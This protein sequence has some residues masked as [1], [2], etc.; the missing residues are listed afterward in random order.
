MCLGKPR[1]YSEKTLPPERDAKVDFYFDYTY[2]AGCHAIFIA[3]L[4]ASSYCSR[5]RLQYRILFNSTS[6]N[7][8]S[9]WIHPEAIPVAFGLQKEG[10]DDQNCVLYSRNFA[11]AFTQLLADQPSYLNLLGQLKEAAEK[12]ACV[13]ADYQA[14]KGKDDPKSVLRKQEGK[15]FSETVVQMLKPYL[16]QYY[17]KSA[18]GE[19][20]EKSQESIKRYHLNLRWEIGNQFLAKITAT[21]YESEY[22]HRFV[23]IVRKGLGCLQRSFDG[24][25]LYARKYKPCR[26]HRQ[27]VHL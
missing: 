3:D 27:T 5:P 18:N 20:V 9:T 25:C 26:S 7:S 2:V 13:S 17:E 8:P 19:Y 15:L 23:C 16:P 1:T 21:I 4:F 11:L 6:I 12:E 24:L 14:N 22:D 10:N